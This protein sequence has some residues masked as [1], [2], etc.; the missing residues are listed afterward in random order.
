MREDLINALLPTHGE[1]ID[2]VAMARKDLNKALPKRFYT[3]AAAENREGA[4]VLTLDGKPARTPGR[5][6]VA[7][8]S[9]EAGDAVAAEWAAQKEFIDPRTM[10]L[11][12][13]VNSALDGVVWEMDGV[14]AEIGKYA[15]TDLLCYRAGDPASLVELQSAHWDPVLTMAREKIGADF[16]VSH[17]MTFVEQPAAA[18]AAARRI[19]DAVRGPLPLAALN[20]M[21]TIMGSCLLALAVS[22]GWMS[23]E[24]AWVAAHVDEDFQIRAWGRDEEAEARRAARWID[25]QAAARL[26]ALTK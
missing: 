11:T 22:Q 18:I 10:P 7:L 23:A 8:P 15:G 20:V 2:P 3:L 1:A 16:A 6:A 5:N 12:R 9:R 19:I 17:S 4:F 25:M 26:Y 13:M 21:T 14:R 24:N